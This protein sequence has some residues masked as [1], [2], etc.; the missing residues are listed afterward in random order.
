MEKNFEISMLLDTYGSL[1]TERQRQMLQMHFDEDMSLAEIAELTEISRQGV[2]DAL[3][4]GEQQLRQY[5]LA[6]GV[7]ERYNLQNNIILELISLVKTDADKNQLLE[8]LE[9]LRIITEGTDG[10]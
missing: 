7:L 4:R 8:R 9:K 3:V 10:I 5:E 2:R 1:L 6:L